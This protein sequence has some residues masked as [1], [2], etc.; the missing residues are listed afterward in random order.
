ML[1]HAN[2]YWATVIAEAYLLVLREGW[3][4]RQNAGQAQTSSQKQNFVSPMV[5][6]N[7]RVAQSEWPN[8][9][10]PGFETK[11]P[12]LQVAVHDGEPSGQEN[13]GQRGINVLSVPPVGEVCSNC[14]KS[15]EKRDHL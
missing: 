13:W 2:A 4:M 10:P 6:E 3:K 14:S 7:L 11:A 8:D 9:H 5:N 1:G 15:N 12:P